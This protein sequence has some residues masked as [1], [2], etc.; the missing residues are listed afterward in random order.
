MNADGSNCGSDV[1]PATDA[2]TMHEQ[3]GLPQHERILKAPKLLQWTYVTSFAVMLL[4]MVVHPG[5]FNA[6]A[7][8]LAVAALVDCVQLY[9][10]VIRDPSME[11]L[12]KL[13]P[14]GAVLAVCAVFAATTAS[15][16]LATALGAD[17]NVA[18]L[19]KNLLTLFFTA[20]YAGYV[21]GLILLAGSGVLALASKAQG[22]FALLRRAAAAPLTAASPS[23]PRLTLDGELRSMRM[24]VVPLFL[25]FAS[26]GAIVFARSKPG[27]AKLLATAMDFRSGRECVD[28]SESAIAS[29]PNIDNEVIVVRCPDPKCTFGSVIDLHKMVV[30]LSFERAECRRT[31]RRFPQSTASEGLPAAGS[32]MAPHSAAVAADQAK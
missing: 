26:A 23:A 31:V 18:P 12:V 28:L 5:L 22:T 20:L 27:A 21:L 8:L 10:K 4:G 7:T 30:R 2:T 29:I 19:A 32:G 15:A 9:W 16:M 17:P 14:L 25:L 1:V 6:G 13:V 3:T 24:F 11:P